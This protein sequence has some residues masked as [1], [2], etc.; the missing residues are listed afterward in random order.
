MADQLT[1]ETWIFVIVENPGKNEH[2]FGLED[3][4]TRVSYIPAFR[5]KEDAQDCLIHLPTQKGKKY[6]VHA[7]MYDDLTR[8]AFSNDFFV[9]MIDGDGKIT[10]KI[11]PDSTN[12]TVH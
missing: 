5:S 2:F 4:E 6:E 11:Y 1:K 8:D 9:F 3:A 10:E 12:A 7:V